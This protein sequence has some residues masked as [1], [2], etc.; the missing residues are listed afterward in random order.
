MILY[1]YGGGTGVPPVAESRGV[2]G[3]AGFLGDAGGGA[4]TGGGADGG[5][6]VSEG[7]AG[8]RRSAGTKIAFWP[9]RR[10]EQ[11][12]R[13]AADAVAGERHR[14]AQ[15]QPAEV[16]CAAQEPR[17]AGKPGPTGKPVPHLAGE[18]GT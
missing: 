9:R 12:E 3:G 1:G 5:G 4:D 11:H 17:T 13:D 10:G 16:R 7:G 8:A 15:P 14:P 18:P 2:G 6:G